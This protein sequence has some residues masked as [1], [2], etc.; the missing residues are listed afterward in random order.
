MG[1]IQ[2]LLTSP[3]LLSVIGWITVP[4]VF[5][6]MTIAMMVGV[7]IELAFWVLSPLWFIGLVS[8]VLG[9]LLGLYYMVLGPDRKGALLGVFFSASPAGIAYAGTVYFS[10][11]SG[12]SF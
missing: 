7:T 11:G 5:M 2:K 8:W 4:I 9:C 3:L 10:A 1:F 6:V 12:I